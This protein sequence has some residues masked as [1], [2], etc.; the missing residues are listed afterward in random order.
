MTRSMVPPDMDAQLDEAVQRLPEHMREGLL[1]YL[2]YGR[3]PGHFLQAVLS[4]DLFDAAARADH[5]NQRALYD[6]VFVLYNYAPS[7]AFG[8]R[9]KVA[10]WIAAGNKLGAEAGG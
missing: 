3:P 6:Y 7:T 5:D 10:E 8:S 2:R 1:A 4:N 9:Q